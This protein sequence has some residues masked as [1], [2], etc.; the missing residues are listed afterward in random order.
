VP[1]QFI[2]QPLFWAR[3]LDKKQKTKNT[4]AYFY[5]LLALLFAAFV[6]STNLAGPSNDISCF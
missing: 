6:F 1:W 4:R 3:Y 2:W 5:L